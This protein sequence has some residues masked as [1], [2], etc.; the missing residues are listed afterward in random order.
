[1][2]SPQS[3]Q[4]PRSILS[5]SGSGVES[6]TTQ[7]SAF[8]KTAVAASAAA[9]SIP[10]KSLDLSHMASSLRTKKRAA[11]GA[12]KIALIVASLPVSLM[13]RLRN[14]TIH[15]PN[16]DA[17]FDGRLFADERRMAGGGYCGS[18]SS[19]GPLSPSSCSSGAVDSTAVRAGGECEIKFYVEIQKVRNI[20]GLLVVDFKRIRGDVWAFKRMYGRLIGEMPLKE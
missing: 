9:T 15:G 16:A 19:S 12:S 13:E 17:G 6:S 1:M 4:S 18:P 2:T 10:K 14:W 3:Q 11:K 20:P 8:S 7:P 5:V